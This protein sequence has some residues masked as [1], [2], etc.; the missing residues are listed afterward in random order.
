MFDFAHNSWTTL[1]SIDVTVPPNGTW[2]GF[3][4][5]EAFNVVMFQ[6]G[7]TGKAEM[8]NNII[9]GDRLGG[10]YATRDQYFGTDNIALSSISSIHQLTIDNRYATA[11]LLPFKNQNGV[12]VAGS[13]DLWARAVA[14]SDGRLYV[15]SDTGFSSAPFDSVLAVYDATYSAPGIANP[16]PLAYDHD[17]NTRGPAPVSELTLDVQAGHVY[18]IRVGSGTNATGTGLLYMQ[19]TAAP[20]YCPSDFNKD[21]TIDF[22]DY[23]DF[24]A[25]FASGC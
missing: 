19:F 1:R 21:G 4:T 24:V 16:V 23:L 9:V 22:F 20:T 17:S 12:V 10:D 8:I 13:Q 14:L 15:R 3:V 11:D 6:A 7:G 5:D 18:A 25:A 2:L